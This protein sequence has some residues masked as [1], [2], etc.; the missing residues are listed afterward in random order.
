MPRV[1]DHEKRREEIA[2]AAWRVVEQAGP[3][4]ANMREIAREAGFGHPVL[5]RHHFAK[6]L[7]TSP[8]SYRR[9]FRG[10]LA[11]VG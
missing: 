6:V 3:Q 7:D 10:Q 11:E 4:G 9:A 5:L 8:Q 1:V 2:E